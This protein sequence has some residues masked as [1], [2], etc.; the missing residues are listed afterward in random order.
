[1]LGCELA[2][3][4]PEP[5]RIGATVLDFLDHGV[6]VHPAPRGI[7]LFPPLVLT[8]AEAGEIGAA[9]RAVFTAGARRG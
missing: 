8:A 9:A 2:G 6:V 1:M 5:E 7:S 3:G 4:R